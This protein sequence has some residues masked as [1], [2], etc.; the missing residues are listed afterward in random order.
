MTQ[1]HITIRPAV[2]ADARAIAEMANELNR[3]EGKP[4]DV[5]SEELVTEQV[6]GAVPLF[7]V[8]VAEVGGALAGYASFVDSYNPEIASP[9]VWLHDL[10]VREHARSLGVGRH[11]MVAVARATLARGGASLSWGVLSSNH[12]A[13][14]FYAGIGARD[15]DVR[16]LELDGEALTRLTQAPRE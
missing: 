3:L 1:T 15:E 2:A 16:I 4:S 10:F 6:L 5:F 9:E 13:R 12:R 7:S 14:A 11:L 8:L